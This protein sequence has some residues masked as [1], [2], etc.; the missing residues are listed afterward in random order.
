[1]KSSG[2]LCLKVMGVAA[3]L[4]LW[5][6]VQVDA[7]QPAVG[8]KKVPTLN[9]DDVRI[10]VDT[11]AETAADETP[12][13]KPAKADSGGKVS[14]DEAGWRERIA[15]ARDKVKS[16]ERAA[17]D[18]ELKRTQLRNDLGTSGQ[19]AKSRNETAADLEQ[20]G[21]QVA[22]LRKQARAAAADLADLEEYGRE[23]KFSEA[24]GPSQTTADGRPN[25]DYYPQRY[26]K[27]ME[28]IKDADR[29]TQVYD[30]RV[31]EISQHILQNGGKNGGDNFYA[32][33]LQQ[34]REDAQ[35]KLDEAKADRVKAEADL[36]ALLEEARRAGVAPGVFRET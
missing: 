24:A 36:D 17:D 26:Q 28:A 8:R 13:A 27:L 32:A 9:S 35:S 30:N 10:P 23:H 18:A 4:V 33:Q 6:G 29:R 16:L 1:M 19:T 15:Q 21:Q 7:Q 12:I 5:C 14:S 2:S 25:E 31:K 34:D 11:G 3:L 22:D 20:T